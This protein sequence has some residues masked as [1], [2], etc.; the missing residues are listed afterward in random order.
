MK[1][2]TDEVEFSFVRYANVWEDADLLMRGLQPKPGSRILSIGSAGDNCFALLESDPEI[3]VAAD[4][5]PAQLCLIELK[6]VAIAHLNYAECL[7]FLGF[8]DHK[9]RVQIYQQLADHLSNDTKVFWDKNLKDIQTGV[10]HAGK[11]ERYFRVFA[12]KVLPFI[13]SKK[14][15]EALL[16]T[17]TTQ[18]QQAFYHQHWNTWRWRLLFKIFFGRWVMGRLGRDPAFL[19]EVKL[20]VGDYIFQKAEKHLCSALA[21][22]NHIL[23]YNLTG[24]FGH[25]LPDYLSSAARFEQLKTRIDR[26]VL[27]KGFAQESGAQY[28]HFDAMNLSDI[29]EYMDEST[30]AAVGQQLMDIANPGCRIAYWNLMAPRRL[31][32]VFGETLRYETELSQQLTAEDR[33]FFYNQII[34]EQWRSKAL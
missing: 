16:S 33:G 14:T 13:H 20:S 24:D 29:F 9:N 3:V 1:K 25:L 31:S 26:V 4:L 22:S 11:F 2:L 8:H 6:K 15:V 10:I 28:G 12:H 32:Q 30:F 7:Q 27:F 5:N 34:I 19:K 21:Q 18:E 23:R 17:K